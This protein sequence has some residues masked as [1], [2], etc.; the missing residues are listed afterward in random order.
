MFEE[1][2]FK[3]VIEKRKALK[4]EWKHHSK[5]L[6]RPDTI[7]FNQK[8]IKLIKDLLYTPM[9]KH[10]RKDYWFIASGAKREMLNNKGYYQSLLNNFPKGTQS[11]SEKIIELDVPRTFP[12]DPFFKDENNRKKLI[13]ILT[14]FVRRNSIIGY[15]QGFNCIAG[16][17]LYVVNDEEQVFWIFT[18]IIENYLPGDFYLLF[19]GVRKDMKVIEAI[20]KKTLTFCN[21]T[22][23][24]SLNNLISKTFISLFSRGMPEQ[25]TFQIWDAF[26]IYGEIVLYRT[27]IWIAYFLCDKS[28]VKKDIEEISSTISN[29]MKEIQESGSLSYFLFMYDAIDY[30]SIKKWKRQIESSVD[31]ETFIKSVQSFDRKKKECDKSLPYCL[32]NNEENDIEKNSNF[33]VHKMNHEIQ[34]YD[35]YF[36]E[37]I[38][39]KKEMDDNKIINIDDNND[40]LNISEDSILIQRQKHL[41]I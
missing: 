14:A 33:I 16:K 38:E 32:C 13:N 23:M 21:Q 36:F 8:E 37:V 35:N 1:K 10:R 18:Q 7:T 28:L 39:Q 40:D 17:L 5:K 29:K 9:S 19:T 26:F 3:K 27:F 24:L 30:R 20:I 34:L 25:I 11:P 15:S 6:F 12:S 4:L 22:I 2:I 41:C 31:N